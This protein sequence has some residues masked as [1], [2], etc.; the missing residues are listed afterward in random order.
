[1]A[2]VIS[3]FC[4]V[5]Y[6][7][8]VPGAPRDFANVDLDAQTTLYS[9]RVYHVDGSDLATE[10]A[11]GPNVPLFVAHRGID[12]ADVAGNRAVSTS[13]TGSVAGP[14]GYGRIAGIPLRAGLRIQTSE[15]DSNLTYAVNNGVC[16]QTGTGKFR[17]ATAIGGGEVV[18][19]VAAAPAEVNGINVLDIRIVKA[20]PA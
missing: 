6:G 17:K 10:G 4:N 8:E 18:G 12:H 5:K 20:M 16:V 3:H 11:S 15:Y 19:F 2:G 13:L 14:S 1:M 7:E 9:G